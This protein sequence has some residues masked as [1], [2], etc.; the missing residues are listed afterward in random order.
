MVKAF[1][2]SNN[3][4][5]QTVRVNTIR[6]VAVTDL[7]PYKTQ[8]GQGHS[9]PI[10]VTVAN[11]GQLTEAFKVIVYANETLI[12][13]TTVTLESGAST[14]LTFEWNTTDLAVGNYLIKAVASYLPYEINLAN[15]EIDSIVQV[16]VPPTYSITFYQTGVGSDFTG[17]AV[18]IDGTNYTALDLPM[19][20]V[21]DDGSSHN[22]SF[23]SPLNVNASY[24]YTWWATSG[25]SSL[26]NGTL[27]V[28]ASGNVTATF[29]LIGDINHDGKVSLG[30]LT[31]FATAYGSHP[32]DP[33]WNPECDV[34][35]Q[36]RINLVD[37]LTL[38]IHYG[39]H[40]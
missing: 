28:T 4:G 1:D 5:A 11:E 3:I 20:F 2:T 12:N 34:A 21:W 18:A 39:D 40:T 24:G 30:D 26:R 31:M 13:T 33:N 14:T 37:L 15:N 27:T 25:L 16:V 6:D 19:S 7:T 8:V 10:N 38:A 32:G 35:V 9:L 29:G 17:T 36:G 22:F 23:T